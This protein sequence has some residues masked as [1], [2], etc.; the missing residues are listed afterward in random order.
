MPIV[1]CPE[2]FKKVSSDATT[3]PH[4]GKPLAF[5]DEYLKQENKKRKRN[6]WFVG[7]FM[8]PFAILIFFVMKSCVDAMYPH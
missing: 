8:T 4:C 2:C 3:C 6:N 7:F 1:P 5:T